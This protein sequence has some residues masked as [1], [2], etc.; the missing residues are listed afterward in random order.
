MKS[1]KASFQVYANSSNRIDEGIYMTN[2]S[3]GNDQNGKGHW[4]KGHIQ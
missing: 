4:H 3:R 2:V 1:S